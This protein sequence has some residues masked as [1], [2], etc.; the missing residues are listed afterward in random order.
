MN[1]ILMMLWQYLHD[2]TIILYYCKILPNVIFVDPK[3]ILDIFSHLI[4]ITYVDHDKLHLIADPPPSAGE[5]SSLI[6]F[7]LFKENFL[8]IIGKEIFNKDFQ[9]SHMIT[10]LKHLHIIAKVENRKEGDYFF[11]CAL[12][13]YD[14]LNPAPAEIQPLLIAWEIKNSG[15]TNLAIPQGLFPLTIVHLL[16]REDVDFSPVGK[17]YYRY[18]DAMSLRIYKEYTIDIINCYTHIEIRFYDCK[19]FCPRI[20]KLVTDAIKKSSKDLNVND[21]HIFAFK[22]SMDEQCYCIV[23]EDKSSTRC[24]QCRSHCKVLEGDDDSYKCWFSNLQL[25]N[26]GAETSEGPPAKRHRM[27]PTGL[28]DTGNLIDVLDVLDDHEYSGVEYYDLGLRLGLHS[29]TLNVIKEDNKGNVRS[30]LREC[31]AAWLEQR[32]SVM[33]R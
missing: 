23:K 33:R 16:E 29:R 17:D 11:P 4:A 32:D 21:N 22:C 8:T 19:D 6:D 14:K 9:P 26:P 13:S 25:L 7:G 18:N 12:P 15:T 3:P 30:C 20:C 27:Q 2:V 24:T 10:L 28:L 1:Q 5:R 31:L